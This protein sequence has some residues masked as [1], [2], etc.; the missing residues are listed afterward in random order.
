[1]VN[2][3][4][5]MLSSNFA[6]ASSLFWLHDDI[7]P[8]PTKTGSP[9]GAGVFIAVLVAVVAAVEVFT[10]EG[11]DPNAVPVGVVSVRDG[12]ASNGVAVGVVF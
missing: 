12:V 7:S 6:V 3:V 11:V 2:T 10:G 1:M 9:D 8:A 5:G 4:P